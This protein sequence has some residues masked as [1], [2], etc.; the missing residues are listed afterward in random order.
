MGGDQKTT[1]T[2]VQ[3]QDKKKPIRMEVQRDPVSREITGLT[4]I[5]E[6]IK[7]EADPGTDL[8]PI[9]ASMLPEDGESDA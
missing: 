9:A 2:E 1:Q 3:N 7:K 6:E 8:T 4:P 5:Y